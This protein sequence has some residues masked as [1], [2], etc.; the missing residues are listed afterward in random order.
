MNE[1]EV[2][3]KRTVL[4]TVPCLKPQSAPRFVSFGLAYRWE[5]REA[6]VVLAWRDN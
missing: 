5:C 1:L 3:I 2:E 6:L 4:R